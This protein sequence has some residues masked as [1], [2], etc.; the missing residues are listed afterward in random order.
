M[1]NLFENDITYLNS[2]FELKNDC[3]IHIKIKKVWNK[4]TNRWKV[5]YYQPFCML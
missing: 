4:I 1:Y 5:A 3:C 2:V